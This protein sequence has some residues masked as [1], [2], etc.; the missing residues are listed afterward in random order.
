MERAEKVRIQPIATTPE[1]RAAVEQT[2]IAELNGPNLDRY[3]ELRG[4][5]ENT[6][7]RFQSALQAVDE[8]SAQLDL[9]RTEVSIQLQLETFK[10]ISRPAAIQIND[11]LKGH[12]SR[13]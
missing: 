11:Y 9:A 6:K 1:A 10:E 4:N 8:K 7:E 2:S 13:R 3:V 5:L 12:R